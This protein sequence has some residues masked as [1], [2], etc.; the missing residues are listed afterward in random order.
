MAFAAISGGANVFLVKGLHDI[1]KQSKGFALRM[2]RNIQLLLK[3]EGFVNAVNDPAKGSYFIEKL[4]KELLTK[5]LEGF[6]R[7]RGFGLKYYE[8]QPKQISS[9][10]SPPRFVFLT[11][12]WAGETGFWRQRR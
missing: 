4:T 5:N 1:D 9:S 6:L 11:L 2:V 3:E 7:L 12:V 10:K 8:T